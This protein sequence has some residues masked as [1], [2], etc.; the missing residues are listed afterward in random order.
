MVTG[1]KLKRDENQFS[2]RACYFEVDRLAVTC[3]IQVFFGHEI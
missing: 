1:E 2:I 3:G